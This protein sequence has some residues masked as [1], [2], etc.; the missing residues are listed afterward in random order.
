MDDI[1]VIGAGPAGLF[2]AVLA[3]QR[4]AKVRVL[5]AGI[6]TTHI[7]PGRIG[8]LD[9]QG[10][11]GQALAAWVRSHPAHPY[12]LA[13]LDSLEEGLGALRA[14]CREAGLQLAG[15]LGRNLR[16]PTAAGAVVPAAYA[17]ESFAAGDLNRPGPVVIAGPAGWRDFYP[18]LCAGNLRRQGF[19]AEG[20]TFEL[21]EIHAIKFDNIATGLARLF[22]RAEVRERVAAQIKARLGASYRV[23]LPAVLGLDD[24]PNAWRELQ[25]RIGAAVFEIPTLPPSVPGIRLYNVFKNALA[26]MGTPVILNMPVERGLVEGRQVT[27]VAVRNVVRE[28]VYRA[29]AVILATGGL[30]GGGITS[31]HHGQLRETA[32]GLPVAGPAGMGDWFGDRLL[33]TDHP[34]H[35]AGVRANRLMQPVD[36]GGAALYDNLRLAGRVLA[37]YNGGCEGSTEGAWI[38][39]ATRAVTSL[40]GTP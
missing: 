11:L 26:R 3:R 13:G 12:A 1:T 30:Y 9:A 19:E 38:A 28:T 20:V 34:I 22:D 25:D 35:Y 17:P 36:E 18:G 4:G 15:G 23:G 6:G 14:L 8:I 16:L 2:S 31:D 10:D 7:M 33:A 40:F 29:G 5:A 39:T 32:F 21:P 24:Y 27:G 37:G